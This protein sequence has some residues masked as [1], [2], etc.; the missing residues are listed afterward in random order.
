MFHGSVVFIGASL[1]LQKVSDLV[2]SDLLLVDD[3]QSVLASPSDPSALHDDIGMA[4]TIQFHPGSN[5]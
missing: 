3:G 2:S 4:V 5:G 1:D